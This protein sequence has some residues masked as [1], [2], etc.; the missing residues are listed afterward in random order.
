MH[1]AASQLAPRLDDIVEAPVLGWMAA[2]LLECCCVVPAEASF[3]RVAAALRVRTH[4][5]DRCLTLWRDRIHRRGW[6]RVWGARWRFRSRWRR[7]AWRATVPAPIRQMLMHIYY[8]PQ[9]KS[10]LTGKYQVSAGFEFADWSNADIMRPSPRQSTFSIENLQETVHSFIFC[11]FI[12]SFIYRRYFK[13]P[14]EHNS[15]S[16]SRLVASIGAVMAHST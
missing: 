6:R 12:H 5:Q 9:I 2:F 10:K 15:G 13:R 11:L 3:A 7:W 1:L 4:L 8:C 14:T 16:H